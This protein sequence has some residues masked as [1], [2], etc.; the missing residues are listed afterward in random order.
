MS[1]AAICLVIYQDSVCHRRDP[2]Y[3]KQLTA[4]VVITQTN[5]GILVNFI[6]GWA[7][8]WM[9]YIRTSPPSKLERCLWAILLGKMYPQKARILHQPRIILPKAKNFQKIFMDHVYR[10]E[11]NSILHGTHKKGKQNHVENHVA[12][13]RTKEVVARGLV[14]PMHSHSYPEG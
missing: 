8:S 6:N 5:T 2:A 3:N 12:R 13:A 4:G 7:C 11:E 1:S 14:Q 9:S 10:K